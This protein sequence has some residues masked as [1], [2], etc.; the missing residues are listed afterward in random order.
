MTS[1]LRKNIGGSLAA[2]VL[3]A[4]AIGISA[5]AQSATLRL[6]PIGDSITSGYLSSTNNG[7]RAGLYNELVAQGN[8]TDFVGSIRD[9][10]TF[11]PDHEGHSGYRIDQVASLLDGALATYQ[12]NVVTLH[13]G[14]NDMLQSY[15]LSTAPNRL[16][17][18]IDQILADDPGVTIVV[19]QIICNADAATQS[20]INSYNS[21]IPGIVQARANAGKH[22]YLVSMSSLNTGDLK[23]GTH[24]NDGG[25]QKMADNWDGAVQQVIGKGWVTNLAWAGV[26]SIQNVGSGQVIDV[27]GG[28]TNSNAPIIQWPYTGARNQMWNFIPTSSGYYQIK[29]ANSGM[30]INVT[31]ASKSNGAAIVQWQFGAAGN[32]QWFP[33]LNSDGTYSFYNRNSGLA[34]DMPGFSQAQGTQFDQWGGNGG[35]NQ[36]FVSTPR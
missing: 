23:D 18:M 1:T 13:I 12:P 24:P 4:L 36:K 19:A 25:Y 32:D 21:Q 17:S 14:T 22:V 26:Y 8:R 10:D 31:A 34:L 35:N 28:S 16:A 30:D 27:S 6:M 9:G 11:D 3:G 2:M 20:R 7:Y 5:P 15:Q 29:S 33:S